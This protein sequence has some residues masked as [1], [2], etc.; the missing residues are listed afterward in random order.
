MAI[1]V[2][3]GDV[4]DY[5]ALGVLAGKATAAREAA[6]RQDVMNRQMMQIQAQ[7]AAQARQYEHQKEMAEFD[8]YMN[9]EKLKRAEAFE[10]YKME[11]RSL[12]DFDMVEAKRVALFQNQLQQDLRKQQEIDAKL[13]TLAKKAPVEM[14][15]D[16]YLSA[17]EYQDAVMKV[18]GIPTPKRAG[19]D[20]RQLEQDTQYYLDIISRYK[21]EHD[22]KWGPG[23]RLGTAV[24]D[25]NG[26]VVREATPAEKAQLEY[27]ERRLAET[28]QRLSPQAGQGTSPVLSPES[29]ASLQKILEEGNPDKMKLA[30][31]RLLGR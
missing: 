10:L 15:G 23:Q 7:A 20:F 27:A 9:T 16:G 2:Q 14:G 25:K 8:A 22:F 28:Q 1:R 21:K 6:A 18:Q 12:H 26:N 24:L 19:A 31:S 30:L 4:K 11:Q 13:E 3:Y 17:Q 29:R 5:A